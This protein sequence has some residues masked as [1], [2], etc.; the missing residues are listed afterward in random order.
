MSKQRSRRKTTEEKDQP[1]TNIPEEVI[2]EDLEE[3]PWLLLTP[4]DWYWFK[5]FLIVAVVCIT[6]VL[7][8]SQLTSGG[9][10]DGTAKAKAL[11]NSFIVD[12]YNLDEVKTETNVDKKEQC[13]TIARSS[14]EEDDS[15][16]LEELLA[17]CEE[18]QNQVEVIGEGQADVVVE[19]AGKITTITITNP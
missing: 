6:V 2:A 16:N 14:I 5:M 4:A 12:T 15:L 11:D 17:E 18:I 10:V 1:S 3:N 13:E 9:S 8:A 7:L 19:V